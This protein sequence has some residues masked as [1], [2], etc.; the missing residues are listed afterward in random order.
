MYHRTVNIT[1]PAVGFTTVCD[2]WWYVCYPIAV[3]VD[4]VLGSRSSTD[5]GM[6]FGAGVSFPVGDSASFYF[7]V[8]YIYIWGP[9]I[10]VPAI[11]S[12]PAQSVSANGQAIPFMFGFRF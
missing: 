6:N 5:F 4:Q 1:T 11:G 10:D 8:R 3:P 12:T 2:P 9:T 7:D